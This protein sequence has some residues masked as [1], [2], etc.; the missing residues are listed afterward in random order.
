VRFGRLRGRPT[1]PF[2]RGLCSRGGRHPWLCLV[3]VCR[4]VSVV[5]CRGSSVGIG[6]WSV[7]SVVGDFG[8]FLDFFCFP[9]SLIGYFD[10]YN[11]STAP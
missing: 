5:S 11:S 4:W 3:G 2:D 10:E 7:F 8:G 6:G 9:G 1:S